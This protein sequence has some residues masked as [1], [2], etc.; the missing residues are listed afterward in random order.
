MSASATRPDQAWNKVSEDSGFDS[1]LG[2]H[3]TW[4]LLW[5]YKKKCTSLGT[6]FVM[7][8]CPEGLLCCVPHRSLIRVSY[9]TKLYVI[10]LGTSSAVMKGSCEETRVSRA[11]SLASSALLSIAVVH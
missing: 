8:S 6:A 2:W 11:N 3:L 10:L 1:Q 5:P 7:R 4:Q 9:V